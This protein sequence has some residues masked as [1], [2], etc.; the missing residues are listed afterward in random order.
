METEMRVDMLVDR[1]EEMRDWGT[2]P[3][4]EALCPAARSW[5]RK[6]VAG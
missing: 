4:I 3:T 6:S 2:P 1:W 5:S